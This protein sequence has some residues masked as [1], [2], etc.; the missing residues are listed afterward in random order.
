M[1]YILK[2]YRQRFKN[3][4]YPLGFVRYKK[5]F[6]RVRGDMLQGITFN[7]WTTGCDLPI[8][9]MPFSAG[10]IERTLQYGNLLRLSM[11]RVPTLPWD[12][13]VLDRDKEKGGLVYNEEVDDATLKEMMEFVQGKI[14]P[15]FELVE[16]SKVAYEI[17][18]GNIPVAEKEKELVSFWENT[19]ALKYH[20]YETV[21]RGVESNIIQT[22]TTLKTNFDMY[23]YYEEKY[24]L[25]ITADSIAYKERMEK[26]IEDLEKTIEKLNVQEY[27]YYDALIKETEENSIETLKTA[28]WKFQ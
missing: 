28:G 14:L 15:L 23:K 12:M 4:L 11:F 18:K 21:I 27:A 26:E 17:T 20:D 9:L 6:Y 5:T 13:E 7:S 22:K 19:L 25:K 10:I 24:G 16:N 3:L 8:I 2:E 1:K